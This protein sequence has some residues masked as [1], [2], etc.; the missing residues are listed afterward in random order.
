MKKR[1]IEE[2]KILGFNKL[3]TIVCLVTVDFRSKLKHLC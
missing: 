2:D 3:K 1:V